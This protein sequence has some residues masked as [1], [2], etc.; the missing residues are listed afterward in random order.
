MVTNVNA[1]NCRQPTI[2]DMPK[3]CDPLAV[4]GAL[5]SGNH[6]R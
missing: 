4:S 1:T 3:A 6:G 5:W 2:C